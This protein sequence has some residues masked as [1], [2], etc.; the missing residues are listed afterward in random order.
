MG[1]DSRPTRRPS[2][3]RVG[4]CCL[5]DCRFW[6][7]AQK[8]IFSG[9]LVAG[10]ESRKSRKYDVLIVGSGQHT[11][12]YCDGFE[13]ATGRSAAFGDGDKG[14]GLALMMYQWS[15]MWSRA[16]VSRGQRRDARP[17]D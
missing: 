10:V 12:L 6:V 14:A 3:A 7:A 8:T 5:G 15:T 17:A 1:Q 16:R 11:S 2:G 13:Y 4:V 9:T